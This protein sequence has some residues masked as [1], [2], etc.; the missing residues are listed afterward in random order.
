MEA[1]SLLHIVINNVRKSD[2]KGA[3]AAARGYSI[4][5]FFA[6]YKPLTGTDTSY[7]SA[8]ALNRPCDNALHNVFLQEDEYYDRWQHRHYHSGH[9]ILPV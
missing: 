2:K 8:S 7:G 6:V 1:R 4:C 3:Y 9:G 5:S